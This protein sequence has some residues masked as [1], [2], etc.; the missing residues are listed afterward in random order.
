MH[1]DFPAKDAYLKKELGNSQDLKEI[2]FAAT[3]RPLHFKSRADTGT[4]RV[5]QPRS[6]EV[7]GSMRRWVGPWG[8][9]VRISFNTTI[10]WSDLAQFDRRK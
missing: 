7:E 8:N 6:H 5:P 9:T 1:D 2:F 3:L 10:I 4:A